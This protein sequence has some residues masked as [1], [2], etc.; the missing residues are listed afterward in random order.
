M[1]KTVVRS[2][3]WGWDGG[4]LYSWFYLCMMAWQRI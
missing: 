4:T 1:L 2:D 3:G